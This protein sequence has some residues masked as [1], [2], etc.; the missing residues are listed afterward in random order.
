[1]NIK[2]LASGS[3]GNAYIADDGNASILIECGIPYSKI[4]KDPRAFCGPTIAGCL[5]SH[6]HKD[7]S[8]CAKEIAR[9]GTDIY[10]SRGTIDMIGLLGHHRAYTVEPLCRFAVGSFSILPFKVEHDAAEPLG[11][12]IESA[13]TGERLL[14]FTDTYFV[15]YR[16]AGLTHIMA[17]ANYD[18]T[19]LF[20]N[21]KE[22]PEMGARKNR[23]IESHM[24]IDNLEEFFKAND[25]TKVKQIFLIHMSKDNA[26][27]TAFKERIQRLTGAEVYAC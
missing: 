11:F 5:I 8:L 21:I 20:D 2:V 3:S 6:E 14:Y 26:D 27:P 23:I 13:F 18:P 1:M 16:F 25:M 19:I 9:R 12:L 17:E 15:R 22:S 7:H 4:P 24:G 10:A